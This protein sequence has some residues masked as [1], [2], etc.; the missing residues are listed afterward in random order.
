DVSGGL[1]FGGTLQATHVNGFTPGSAET[2]RVLRFGSRV[3][4]SQFASLDVPAG[5]GY[6][7]YYGNG[8]FLLGIGSALTGINE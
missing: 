5:F 2:F 7:S 4:S 8:N 3:G 6:G 1:T